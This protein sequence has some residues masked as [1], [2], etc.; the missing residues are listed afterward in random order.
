MHLPELSPDRN[1]ALDLVRVTEAAAIS[2]AVWMGRANK[3]AGDQAAVDAMR[4]FLETVPIRGTI[5]IGEGEKDEAPMLYSGET[6][7]SGEGPEMDIA[8]DPVEGTT[9]LAHGKEHALSVIG[10][11]D[12]N[13]M[14]DPGPALYMK[15]IV[16]PSVAKSS[17]DLNAS[18][19][20]N[21]GQIAESLQREVD[22]ITVFVLDKPRH[23]GL[24]EEIRTAGARITLHSDG[25]VMGALLAAT[26]NTGVDVMMG[27]GGTPEGIIT[28]AAIKALHAG[29]QGQLD[30]QKDFEKKALALTGVDLSRIFELKD[31]ICSDHTFF[32]AT[33]ITGGAF[34]DG[35]IFEAKNRVST[36]SL[37]IRSKTRSVRYIKGIHYLQA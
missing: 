11:S 4:Q 15:K 24:I 10:M 17:I 12:K 22:E 13:S 14:W 35:V 1:L 28:A 5:V 31:F 34:L 19:A 33:G 23:Q 16:V 29:M 21:L 3:N 36:H 20:E 30:P 8:V 27:T 2:S 6:V 26:P 9:L 18:V 32:A 37:A 7:G 25:D